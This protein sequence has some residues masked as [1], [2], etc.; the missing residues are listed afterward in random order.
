MTSNDEVAHSAACDS[1]EDFE[2]AIDDA[3]QVM[4]VNFRH[5]EE[6]YKERFKAIG[7]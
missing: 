3:L 6:L 4:K 5:V 1:N 7:K 2:A